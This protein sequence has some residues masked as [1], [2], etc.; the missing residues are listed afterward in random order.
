MLS[1]QLSSATTLILS[2]LQQSTRTE[3][4]SPSVIAQTP[5]SMELHDI[6]TVKDK[7]ERSEL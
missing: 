1:E 7:P 4:P 6:Q 5:S 2:D 3:A